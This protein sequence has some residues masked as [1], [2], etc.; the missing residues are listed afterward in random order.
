MFLASLSLILPAA[1]RL[2]SLIMVPL[3]L[4]RAVIGF[5]LTFAFVAWA[6]AN[7]W[8]KLGRIQPA[9]IYGG[10][11]LLISVPARRALGFTDAWVP[12]AQ[13][14]IGN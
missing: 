8:R 2:D 4:P 12:I 3:G 7:D 11:A 13:W 10:I 6:W 14:L 9:Y 1:G 5:W